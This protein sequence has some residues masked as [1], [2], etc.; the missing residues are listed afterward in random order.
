MKTLLLILHITGGSIAILSGMIALFL[1]KGSKL[2]NL[3]GIG[4]FYS[5]LVMAGSAAYL[6]IE[7]HEQTNIVVSF[8]AI[9]LV[10]TARKTI[11]NRGTSG[12][13]EKF[14]VA[15]GLTIVALGVFLSIEVIELRGHQLGPIDYFLFFY[16][17]IAAVGTI[18]DVRVLLKGQINGARRIVRHLWR[19][20]FALWI[21]VGALFLGQPQVFPQVLQENPAILSI[22]FLVVTLT[23]FFWL[24]RVWFVGRFKLI[25]R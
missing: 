16:T 20:T 23:L 13:F 9:Y 5:M 15:F 21:A 4:F 19:M 7:N 25:K 6:S 17:L 24:A 18:L 11:S 1:R 2:H 12:T 10:T 22:P 3:L 14:A 8:L